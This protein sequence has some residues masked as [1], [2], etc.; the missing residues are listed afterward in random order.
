[1]G[2][3]LLAPEPDVFTLAV[4]SDEVI[5]VLRREGFRVA[6]GPMGTTVLSR[7]LRR[8]VVPE[9]AYF[10]RDVLV[11][12]LRSAGLAYYDFL[13]HLSDSGKKAPPPAES[14]TRLCVGS[15]VPAHKESSRAR[16]S[17]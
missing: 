6:P 5:G 16:R 14:S 17:S 11:S 8:V 4:S 9:M 1:M 7:D 2:G 10:P 13:E 15:D 12:I 3:P